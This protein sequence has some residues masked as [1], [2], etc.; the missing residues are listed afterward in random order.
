MQYKLLFENWRKH[1]IREFSGFEMPSDNASKQILK[2]VIQKNAKNITS[3]SL[4]YRLLTSPLTAFLSILLV[5]ST[6]ASDEEM[7]TAYR[8]WVE[9]VQKEYENEKN[10][11]ED[12]KCKEG[13]YRGQGLRVTPQA[14]AARIMAG[15][16]YEGTRQGDKYGGLYLSV[17]G[18]NK[19]KK[20]NQEICAGT[21]GYARDSKN[22][23]H[24]NFFKISFECCKEQIQERGFD[25]ITKIK[26]Q[27]LIKLKQSGLKVLAAYRSTPTPEYLILDSTIITDIQKLG[28]YNYELSYDENVDILCAKM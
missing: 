6:T 5:P 27:E 1:L 19:V 20:S 22:Q 4:K 7:G 16:D 28:T 12:T 25:G 18:S 21:L 17:Y 11:K 23:N 2:K 3:R 14:N 15:A 26:K 24:E 13:L 8:P 9:K 10:K